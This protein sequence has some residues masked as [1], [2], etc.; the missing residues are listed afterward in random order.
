MTI[1][2]VTYYRPQAQQAWAPQ[3]AP[4][5][6]QMQ[7]LSFLAHG[8]AKAGKSTFADSGPK[9]RITL[10]VEGS[11]YWTPSQKIYWDPMRE[12]VPDPREG[13]ETATVLVREARTVMEVFRVLNSGQHPFNSGAMDSVTEVQQRIIDDLTKGRQMDRDKWNALLRQVNLM[14]RSYR[15]LITHPVRPLWSMT[16]VA[17]TKYDDRTQR[18]RPMVQGQ[19]QDYLPYYV[20]ILGYIGA[21]QDN[22]RQMLIGPNPGFETGE[23][24]GGRLPSTMLLG[25]PG[26]PGYTIETMLQQVLTPGR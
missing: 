6:R 4:P 26:R 24:I 14:V 2:P 15:D 5:R 22:S 7:G 10:D 9:P 25:Y 17:G 21:L 16:F 13:W 23:R 12:T 20:D 11:S 8:N 18:W 19:A 1:Q 3:P